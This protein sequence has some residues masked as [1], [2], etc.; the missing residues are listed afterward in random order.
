MAHDLALGFVRRS[1]GRGHAVRGQLYV[2]QPHRHRGFPRR[3]RFARAAAQ[4][5]RAAID[6]A[7]ADMAAAEDV[8]A[9]DKAGDEFRARPLVDFLG[10][11]DLLD[12]AR[13]HHD[14]RIGGCHRLA[15]VVRDIDRRVL[16]GVVQ[17][18]D[19]EAHLL[20]QIGVEI[21]ERLVEQKRF[22]FDDERAR[23]RRALLLAAGQF[24]RIARRQIG[25][26]RHVEDRRDPALALGPVEPAQFSP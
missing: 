10:R 22:R 21:G 11:A 23:E 15:L 26:M 19:L 17:A 7:V 4:Q 25:E 13:I 9:A 16:V 18:A 24:M 12:P 1:L 2:M 14:D 20:A 3:G 8:G 5:T 6:H